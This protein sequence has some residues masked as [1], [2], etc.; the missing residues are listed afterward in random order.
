MADGVL[1]AVFADIKHPRLMPLRQ[2]VSQLRVF[3]RR[4]SYAPDALAGLTARRDPQLTLFKAGA[5]GFPVNP[6][7]AEFFK[8]DPQ[9]HRLG[10]YDDGDERV[11]DRPEQDLAGSR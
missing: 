8:G 9:Q 6:L 3:D 11:E 1:Q 2:N 7:A 5:P 10:D 4:Q